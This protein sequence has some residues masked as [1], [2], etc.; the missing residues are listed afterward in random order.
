V[1]ERK[2]TYKFFVKMPAG[3]RPLENLAVRED[4]NY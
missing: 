3:K 2:G 1:R 4:Y